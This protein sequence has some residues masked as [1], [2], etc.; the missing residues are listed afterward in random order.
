MARSAEGLKKALG[1]I[2]DLRQK[3]WRDV[4]VLGGDE[5]PNQ[6]L[7]KAGRVADFFELAELMCIDALHRERI[8][9]RPLPRRIS[10]AGWRGAAQRREV[11]LRRRVGVQGRGERARAAQGAAGVRRSEAGHEVLQ[12]NL[13][14]HVWRQ[15]SRERGR[16]VR[17]RTRPRTSAP[18]RR[19]SRCSTSSTRA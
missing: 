11:P 13:T 19:F 3:Y 16:R 9:R 4:R 10:D 8:V 14:L 1:L 2:R 6:A 18:T 12:M 7:E 5:E 17:R 15:K